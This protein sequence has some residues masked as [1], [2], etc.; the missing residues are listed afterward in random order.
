MHS[1]SNVVILRTQSTHNMKQRIFFRLL[2]LLVLD[3]VSQGAFAQHT[4]KIVM[5]CYDEYGTYLLTDSIVQPQESCFF[6]VPPKIPFYESKTYD[7]KG[8]NACLTESELIVEYR[9]D[10]FTGFD[11]LTEQRLEI[12]DKM[13]F[14][15][16]EQRDGV[17][18]LWSVKSGSR[19]LSLVPLAKATHSPEETWIF[20]KDY[21]GWKIQNQTTEMYL[22]LADDGTL[23]VSDEATLFDLKTSKVTGEAWKIT[24]VETKRSY[25]FVP[26]RY[27][28]RPYYK[29]SQLFVD[30]KDNTIAA[31]QELLVRAGTDVTL[32]KTNVEKFS[33]K[34]WQLD[35]E[36]RAAEDTVLNMTKSHTLK[37]VY[38][39]V[40][41][42]SA[43]RAAQRVSA[44]VDLSGRRVS[45][46][47]RGWVIQNGHISWQ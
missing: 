13:S 27:A 23:T 9:T 29:L 3:V 26:R 44:P 43:V 34:S 22:K 17:S 19:A 11:S 41:A 6:L 35:D 24:D 33:F 37:S 7:Q 32:P 12:A 10:A 38:G 40:A 4:K 8:S 47:Y 36:P 30:D 2:L 18:Y 39:R 31:D 14:V 15:L 21:L 1:L 5:R 25:S 20:E 28:V 45:K 46:Q 42:L 16:T